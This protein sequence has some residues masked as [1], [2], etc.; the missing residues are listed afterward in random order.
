MPPAP[1]K[2]ASAGFLS[3]EHLSR[4]LRRRSVRGGVATLIGQ[5]G[6]F[7]LNLGGTAVLARILSP[8]DFGLLAMVATFTRLIEQ[9]KDMGL[10]SATVSRKELSPEQV[11]YLFWINVALGGAAAL[12]ALLA[13]PAI[14]WFYKEPVLTGITIALASGFFV[15]GLAVQHQALLQRQ[16]Q[17]RSLAVNKLI[18]AAVGTL[19]GIA[20]ACWGAGYWS[21]VL[22]N[23]VTAFASAVGLWWACGWRPSAPRR[24]VEG[25]QS[26]LAFGWHVTGTRTLTFLTRNLDNIL[27]GK[28]WGDVAL[29]YYAKA[30]Q[31]LMLPVQQLINPLTTVVVPALSR[32][33][34]DQ[35]AYIRY[36]QRSLRTLTTVTMPVVAL[37][38]VATRELILIVLGPRWE[39]CV[40]IFQWLAPAAFVGSFNPIAWAWVSLNQTDRMLRWTLIATP[41]YVL[42]FALGVPFGA[43]G[44]AAAFSIT[45]LGL[46]YFSINYCFRAN[47]LSFRILFE[48]TWQATVASLGAAVPL[49]ALSYLGVF[50]LPPLLA[51]LLEAVL[52]TLLYFGLWWCLPGGRRALRETLSLWRDLL[53][54]GKRQEKAVEQPGPTE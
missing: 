24:N 20:A 27:I 32:L 4:N 47:F 50:A 45:Q 21:L 10:A 54:A 36:Y 35:A 14:A 30:Y 19:A 2:P 31:I 1:S 29:G 25:V 17:L 7:V 42:G 11:N 40:R 48:A 16:M 52:Y 46:R 15:A 33:Q 18:A 6:T 23:V 28:F 13:A 8:R 39:P 49:L 53:P 26:L 51:L 9:L 22:M 34:H 41:F 43:E 5:G 12:A 38:F 3:T 37:C 44:V